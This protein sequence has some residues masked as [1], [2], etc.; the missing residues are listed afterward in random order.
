MINDTIYGIYSGTSVPPLL[1]P[2]A[3]TDTTSANTTTNFAFTYP[4]SEFE[5][6]LDEVQ[7]EMKRF[8]GFRGTN[9]YWFNRLKADKARRLSLICHKVEREEQLKRF[10]K[11]TREH[12][13]ILKP[14]AGSVRKWMTGRPRR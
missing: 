8:Q 7:K 12:K 5:F 11:V 1:Y 10:P 6:N 14:R 4:W 13:I 2:T 9:V 3:N